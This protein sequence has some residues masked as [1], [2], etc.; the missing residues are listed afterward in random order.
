MPA[1]GMQLHQSLLHNG[2]T[3]QLLLL[4]PQNGT[5]HTCFFKDFADHSAI[6]PP[7]QNVLLPSPHNC[8]SVGGR[9]SA[10]GQFSLQRGVKSW[11]QQPA[12]PAQLKGKVLSSSRTKLLV[13][14]AQSKTCS[15]QHT[16]QLSQADG[17]HGLTLACR[18][19]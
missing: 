16:V 9:A 14:R 3:L 13:D 2:H 18:L 8:S 5:R 4:L 7:W 1:T 6:V 12:P 10:G 17:V 15:S 19:H 11:L